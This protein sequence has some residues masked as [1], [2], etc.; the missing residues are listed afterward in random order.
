MAILSTFFF[1]SFNMSKE[2]V[3]VGAPVPGPAEADTAHSG[4]DRSANPDRGL[5]DSTRDSI[6]PAHSML[7]G[8]DGEV[9]SA[10]S[11]VVLRDMR[12]ASFLCCRHYSFFPS[13]FHI[14]SILG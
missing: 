3:L 6:G 8:D 5:R 2:N 11:S 9:R 13:F 12:P 4:P 10:Q 7:D 14:S 1:M